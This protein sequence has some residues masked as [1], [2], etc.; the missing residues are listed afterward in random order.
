[1][2]IWLFASQKDGR[3]PDDPKFLKMKLGLEREPNLKLLV[4]HGLPIPEQSASAALA[5]DKRNAPLE[6][7]EKRT[8]TTEEETPSWFSENAALQVAWAM[9]KQMRTKKGTPNTEHAM[10]LSLGKLG[11]LRAAGEDPV[12][13]VDQ[14]TERG[15]TGLFPVKP[16]E[17]TLLL[18]AW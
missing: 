3:V 6:E 15:W 18:T 7:T 1:M 4:D 10:K 11:R 17:S 14:S 8:K 13:V 12:A 2:L 9:W 16:D 5:S